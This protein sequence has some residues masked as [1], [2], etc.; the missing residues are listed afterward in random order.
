MKKVLFTLNVDGYAPEITEHTFPLLKQYAHKIGAEFFEITERKSPEFPPVYE[1]LQIYDLGKGNDWNIY[2]DADTL[3]RPDFPDVTAFYPK[4][5]VL[6]H[7]KDFASTRW[8]MDGY[9]LR[10]GR[11]IGACNWFAVASDW[12]LDLWKPLDV[13]F[14]EA[15]ENIFPTPCELNTVV[16]RD[17]LIDDYVLS[18]NIARFGLKHATIENH[19]SKY[20]LRSADYLWHDYLIGI[21]EKVQWILKVKKAWGIK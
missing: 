1:K 13:P 19:M 18:Q 14:I 5:T 10:D 12:C 2:I 15:V 16:S 17:H 20:G 7:G 4:D 21:D 8:R 9:F 3:M 11:Q 6:F